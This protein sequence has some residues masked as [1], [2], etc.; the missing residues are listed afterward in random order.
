MSTLRRP[1]VLN[2]EACC[3][4]HET[5]SFGLLV[6][7]AG[8]VHLPPSVNAG[9]A[10]T[11]N[12]PSKPLGFWDQDTLNGDWGGLRK[13]LEDDGFKV[14]PSYTA[15]VIG[16]PSGGVR[17]GVVTDGLV[18]MQLDFDLEKMTAEDIDG[19]HRIYS[20]A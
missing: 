10:D 16:N 4:P 8:D 17:Q 5:R 19:F 18:N 14:T 12:Q 11:N 15:L 9:P 3:F 7:S 6:H 20:R 1:R 13:E 2:R